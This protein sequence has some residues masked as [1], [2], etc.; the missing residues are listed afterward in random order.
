[1]IYNLS[2][3]NINNTLDEADPAEQLKLNIWKTK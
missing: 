2:I 1:M 3:Y